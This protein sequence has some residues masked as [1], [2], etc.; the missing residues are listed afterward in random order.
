MSHVPTVHKSDRSVFDK[1][2]PVD[3]NDTHYHM[4]HAF[5]CLLT[6]RVKVSGFFYKL[7]RHYQWR[8]NSYKQAFKLSILLTVINSSCRKRKRS[9]VMFI[10]RTIFF[11]YLYMHIITHI[12]VYNNSHENKTSDFDLVPRL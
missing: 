2:L 3:D 6:T 5:R 10:H 7:I 12:Y 8:N 4:F 11:T 9:K 1:M